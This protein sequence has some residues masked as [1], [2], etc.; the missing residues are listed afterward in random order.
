MPVQVDVFIDPVT[1]DLPAISRLATG[2]DLIEARIRL[3]LQRGEGEWFLD[4]L[5]VGLPLIA[6]RQQK[7]PR[8]SEILQRLQREIRE[9]PGVLTTKNWTGAHDAPA[10]RLTLSG[11]VIVDDGS[12]T[13][14][15]V[16][17]PTDAPRNTLGFSLLF[18]RSAGSGPIVRAGLRGP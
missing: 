10:R 11:D 13:S 8:V 16:S 3:R 18:Y 9:V 6:W 12:V 7:P 2:L 4:P 5:G 14:L 15:V 1:G 17:A